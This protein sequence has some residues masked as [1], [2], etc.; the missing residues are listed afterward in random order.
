MV[1]TILQIKTHL[2]KNTAHLSEEQQNT[3]WERYNKIATQLCIFSK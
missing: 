2:T 3:Y 1:E